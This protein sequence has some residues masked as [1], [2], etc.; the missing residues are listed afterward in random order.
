MIALA[1]DLATVCGFAI[2]R[3]DGKVRSGAKGFDVTRTCSEGQRW[4]NF[5]HWLVELKAEAGGHLDIVAYEDI[6]FLGAGMSSHYPQ[7]YGGMKAILLSFCTHH[8]IPAKPW[9]A[10]TIKKQWT[11]SGACDKDAMK[12]RC[13]E[14]GFRPV[15]DNEADAIALLHVATGRVP[16]LPIE[17]QVK[18]RPLRA[19]PDTRSREISFPSSLPEKPF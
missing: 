12:A 1:L 16:K 2:L 6:V 8:G 17:R 10:T 3:D 13:R 15:D 18:K 11:G 7:L 4:I 9:N 14:L 19:N 5:R